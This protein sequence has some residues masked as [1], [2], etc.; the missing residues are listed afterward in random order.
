MLTET[1]GGE[2]GR[3]ALDPCGLTDLLEQTRC[4]SLL[5]LAERAR[6]VTGK[7]YIIITH[8]LCMMSFDKIKGYHMNRS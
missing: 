6:M 1:V 2:G 8:K 4:Q 5:A 3:E 7:I